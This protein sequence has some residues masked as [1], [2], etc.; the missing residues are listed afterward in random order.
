MKFLAT[1]LIAALLVTSV[2]PVRSRQA[3]DQPDIPAEEYAIYAAVIGDML[4][5][6][7]DYQSVQGRPQPQR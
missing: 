1:S 2:V 4:A 3:D 7:R 6:D 5:D